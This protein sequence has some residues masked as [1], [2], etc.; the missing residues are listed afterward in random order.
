MSTG[1]VELI[2]SLQVFGWHN[3]AAYHICPQLAMQLDDF[4]RPLPFSCLGKD[5]V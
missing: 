1:G 2:C 5:L 3:P 4:D